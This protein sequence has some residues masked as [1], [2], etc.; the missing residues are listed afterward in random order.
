MARR[1]PQRGP[2]LPT[3]RDRNSGPA[4]VRAMNDTSMGQWLGL[5]SLG[6]PVLIWLVIWRVTVRVKRGLGLSPRPVAGPFP[7]LYWLALV[8]FSLFMGLMIATAGGAIY[9][10][11]IKPAAALVCNGTVELLSRAYSY[12]PGQHGVTRIVSCVADDGSRTVITLATVAAASALYS[13]LVFVLLAFWRL[14]RA[15]LAPPRDRGVRDFSNP[16]PAP[17][18]KPPQAGSRTA[19]DGKVYTSTHTTVSV[20]GPVRVAKLQGLQDL[21]E[22]LRQKLGNDMAGLVAGA[23]RKAQWESPDGQATVSD[24][25]ADAASRL[26]ALQALRDQGLIS[27]T[28]YEAKRTEII[29]NL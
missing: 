6:L 24:G 9:P 17:S 12:R 23:L 14:L 22:V 19:Q 2:C 26:R 5:L 13:A 16:G 28:E 11:M 8:L 10:P 7:R 3:R 21:A 1:A 4:W 15:G 25:S 20:D 27:S 29:A 18:A